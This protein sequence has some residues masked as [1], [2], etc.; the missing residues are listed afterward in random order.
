MGDVLQGR[1][2][3]GEFIQINALLV[4][5]YG[6]MQW[7]AQVNNWF[8]RAMAGAERVFEVLDTTPEVDPRS[9]I[10]HRFGVRWS[11]MM[12]G[13]AMTSRTR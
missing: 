7:F 2:S 12:C 1:L 6:P 9:T 3:L 4:M 11:L 10:E 8:S 5:V 13:L